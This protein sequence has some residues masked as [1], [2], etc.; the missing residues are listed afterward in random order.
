M[1]DV[2]LEQR[3]EALVVDLSGAAGHMVVV[4][5]P[6]SGKSTL[7]RT[8]VTALALT[9]TP[10]ETQFYVLDFG[11]GTFTALRG[12]PHL[13]GLAMRSEPDAV[14][15]TIAEISG[16]VDAREVYF[17]D[18]G[19][20]SMETYRQRRAAGQADD[21]WGDIFLVVDGWATLRAE[22]EE[23][24]QQIIAI[25]A[26]GL[27][28]GVH[29]ILTANRWMEMRPQIRDVIGTRFELR[30]GDPSDSE[31][32][33]KAA[34]NVPESLPGRGLTPSGLHLLSALPRIDGDGAAETLADG[35]ADLVARVQSAWH[36]P[37]GPKLRMLPE[38]IDLPQVQALA[39]P[40]DRRLLLGVDEQA[41]APFG[42]DLRTSPHLYAF[43]D[44][45]TGKSSLLR[46]CAAEIVRL[47]GPSE[48]KIFVVDYR[49][50]LLDEV[51]P[52]YLGAYLT[53]H[54][55]AS[56]GMSELAALFS[57]RIPGP[58][59]TAEELRARS[60]WKGAEGFVLI[61]DYD[62]VSTSQGNPILPL[63]PLLAQASDVG[64]HVVVVRRS[65]GA[66]RALYDPVLQR[67]GDLG[68]TG[69][70][71]PGNPEE[72]ALIG[73]VKPAA[74]PPGR[75]QVVSRE[76]GVFRGQ[77]AFTPSSHG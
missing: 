71:L 72:G 42:L 1:V 65:G 62:L 28:Y 45:E 40:E 77:L 29:V 58:G 55:L 61:D 59:V 36:G 23:L 31:V 68:A 48:A 52:E 4:G 75:V 44:A 47:Y 39:G 8:A 13:A 49:R 18:A 64:L 57:S 50:A 26:R 76:R 69:I 25:A 17:R 10:L 19:V 38:R 11:G 66:S 41:L 30:L 24:E 73:R 9:T 20:D 54:E 46:A 16:I 34:R 33:R 14:R 35:V 53:S 74:G 27:T 15:R 22:F 3:R 70:L 7:L 56:G 12:L 67:L 2:P 43:G 6:L 32:D 63:V 37:A 5:R 60:W 21:G 51:P